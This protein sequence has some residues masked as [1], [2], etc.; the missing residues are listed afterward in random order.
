M[1][2]ARK[3]RERLFKLQDQDAPITISELVGLANEIEGPRGQNEGPLGW[4]DLEEE[5]RT[6]RRNAEYMEAVLEKEAR[7]VINFD[8]LTLG[9][10][11]KDTEAW[12]RAMTRIFEV[13]ERDGGRLDAQQADF[14]IGIFEQKIERI[15][16]A[17]GAW[18][19]ATAAPTR[20]QGKRRTK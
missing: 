11:I 15:I 16:A 6:A 8:N 1:I 9:S 4:T 10:G 7:K 17:N 14:L 5:A 20:D 18:E 19:I 12:E 2:T 3:M 13:A